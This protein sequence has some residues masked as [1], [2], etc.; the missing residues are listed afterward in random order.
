MTT[1]ILVKFNKYCENGAIN[2]H[3]FVAI[4]LDLLYKFDY[5][6]LYFS[7]MYGVDKLKDM[8]KRLKDIVTKLFGHYMVLIPFL[9]EIVVP[10]LQMMY[11]IL[12]PKMVMRVMVEIICLDEYGDK[13]KM[14][15]K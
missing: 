2:Y 14:R 7:R 5:I 8:S 13:T 12:K 9:F 6:E 3:M 1:N 10:C 4:F 11:L 15:C